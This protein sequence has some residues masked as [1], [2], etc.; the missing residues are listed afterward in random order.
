MT[1]EIFFLKETLQFLK[2]F[3]ELT[4]IIRLTELH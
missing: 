3:F 4:Y 1:I 2:N